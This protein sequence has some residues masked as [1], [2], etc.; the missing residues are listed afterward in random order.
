MRPA[1]ADGP[2]RAGQRSRLCAP[3]F[4]LALLSFLLEE[5][6]ERE[7]RHF[8]SRLPSGIGGET[9][10]G[11]RMTSKIEELHQHLIRRHQKRLEAATW[12][13]THR[14]EELLPVRYMDNPIA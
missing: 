6:G 8:C 4:P 3:S 10:L 9:S 12:L 7:S 2:E 5:S 11:T 14:S 1:G 13:H